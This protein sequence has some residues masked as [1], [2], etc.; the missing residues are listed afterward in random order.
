MPTLGQLAARRVEPEVPALERG[1]ET[2]GG[3]P[4]Q[5]VQASEELV[6]VERLDQVIVGTGVE[7]LD[8]IRCG[9]TGG[10]YQDR[11]PDAGRP[12]LGQR[13]ETGLGRHPPVEH[14]DLVVVGA[15]VDQRSHAVGDRIDGV[16]VLL[17]A[18]R[19]HSAQRRVVLG[20]QHSHGSP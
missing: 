20:N 9:V 17:E 1:A 11:G 15:E 19:Q 18:A 4:L 10:Q 2:Q 6:E 8:P 16:A 12:G 14:R 7:P 3:P 5:S 13:L